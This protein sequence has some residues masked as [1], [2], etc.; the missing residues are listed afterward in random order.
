MTNENVK[1]MADRLAGK[2]GRCTQP[3]LVVDLTACW[4]KM[5]GYG[6]DAKALFKVMEPTLRGLPFRPAHVVLRQGSQET[7]TRVDL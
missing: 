6:A 2:S 7:E 4:F 5:Q 3:G 1:M